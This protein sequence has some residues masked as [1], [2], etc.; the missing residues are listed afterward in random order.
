[1]PANYLE[2][3]VAEWHEYRGYFVRRNVL[4]GRR[5]TGGYECE[6][7]VVAYHPGEGHLVHFETSMDA[8][9]WHKRDEKYKRK[10]AAGQRY[11]NDVF[12]GIMLPSTLHQSALLYFASKKNRVTV[13]GSLLSWFLSSWHKSSG[14][15]LESVWPPASS[16]STCQSSV[17]Y[18]W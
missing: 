8:L 5:L 11:I 3:L 17:H 2:Q 9:S 18:K 7:D 13:G 14:V 10:F 16:Q 4:V 1:M 15:C 12:P 6:L